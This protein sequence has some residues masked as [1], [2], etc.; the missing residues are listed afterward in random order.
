MKEARRGMVGGRLMHEV[1]YD[2]TKTIP[3]FR[4]ITMMLVLTGLSS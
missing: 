2:D 3:R 1:R 4:I